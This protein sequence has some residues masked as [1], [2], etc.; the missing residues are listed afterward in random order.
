MIKIKNNGPKIEQTNYWDTES[1]KAGYLYLSWN[2]GAARLLVPDP[3][4]PQIE[5]M[6]TAKDIII[7]RGPWPDQGNRDSL[8]IL[9]E[10]GSSSPF[11]LHMGTENTDRLLSGDSR[12]EGFDVYIY[13]REGEQF[14]RPGKYRKVRAIPC[15]DPW[16]Q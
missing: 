7:S 9:F 1:A 8:E 11:V 13:T 2:A 12:Q 15:L 16:E 10:D 6:K 3:L 4:K 5:E 14:T